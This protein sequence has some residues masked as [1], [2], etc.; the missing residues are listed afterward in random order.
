MSGISLSEL[1]RRIGRDKALVSR[2]AKQGKIPRLDNGNFDEEAVRRKLKGN[3][4]PARAKPLTD[5][6]T[7]PLTVNTYGPAIPLTRLDELQPRPEQYR[8]RK[9]IG[10]P[11]LRGTFFGLHRMA[12][13]MPAKAVEAALASGA[14]A[15]TAYAMRDIMREAICGLISDLCHEV[16]ISVPD[17]RDPFSIPDHLVPPALYDMSPEHIA[18]LA[19]EPVDLAAWQA[20]EQQVQERLSHAG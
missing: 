19:R 3:L 17:D 1:A 20:W 8:E 9:D 16:G 6:D 15:Q 7:K 14:P 13:D 2:W 5:A 11:F 4:D 18:A 12:F 10:E